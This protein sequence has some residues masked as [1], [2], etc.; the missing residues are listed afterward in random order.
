MKFVAN[1]GVGTRDVIVTWTS[2]GH[3]YRNTAF[4]GDAGH[5]TRATRFATFDERASHACTQMA[6][7]IKGAFVAIITLP[8]KARFVLHTPLHTH[9]HSAG[10]FVIKL[11]YGTWLALA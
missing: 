2:F 1:F 7:I 11:Q 6:N 10:V 5:G 9:I 3:P 4:T 8:F